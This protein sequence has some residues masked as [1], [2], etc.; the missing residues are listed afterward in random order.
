MKTAADTTP[1]HW[2]LGRLLAWTTKH[3]DLLGSDARLASEVLLS[4]AIG[5]RRIDLY[6]RFDETPDEPSLDRFRGWV[7]R[8][9][10]GEPIAYLVGEKEFFS[11]AFQVTPEVLIPRPETEVLVEC[12]LDHCAARKLSQPRLL[13]IGTGSGCIAVA[14][15]VRLNNA[16]VVATDISEGAL[17]LASGNAQ[18]HGV[19]DR[20]TLI[21]ADR[22]QQP[23][24]GMLGEPFD[25][26]I[27]NPPYV[28]AADL[29]SL[30]AA[31]REFEPTMALSDGDDGLSFYRS[32]AE[33]G[34][35]FL[36]P[37]GVVFVEVGDGAAG[38]VIETMESYGGLIHQRTW[39]D[40]VV[41]QERVLMF[42]RRRMDSSPNTQ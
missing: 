13:D 34:P 2:T 38:N 36:N 30:D 40:R 18:R 26:L 1:T 31:V 23:K 5:C 10:C 14:L 35:V 3:L 7:R 11:L 22:L 27:S 24:E 32:I 39:I 15:L 29:H 20:M 21:K 16:T 6:T 8:A 42:S 37:E 19:C 17:R 9:A 4:H 33:D 28:P 25:V 41:G 12:V